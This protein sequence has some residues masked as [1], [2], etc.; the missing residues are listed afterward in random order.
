MSFDDER[1]GS[2][3]KFQTTIVTILVRVWI[4]ISGHVRNEIVTRENATLKQPMVASLGLCGL[5]GR[6]TK[7]KSLIQKK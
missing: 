2:S 1:S 7:V 4:R 5:V 3:F 6:F